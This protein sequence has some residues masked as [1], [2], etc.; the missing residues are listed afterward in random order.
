MKLK[1]EK[2]ENG[3]ISVKIG[4]ND[5]VTKDYIKMIKDIKNG[6]KIEAEFGDNISKEERDSVSSMFKDINSIKETSADENKEAAAIE[7]P[8]GDINPDDLPF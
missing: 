4:D 8:E 1:F 2:S 6:E 7:Y 3:V 5:F